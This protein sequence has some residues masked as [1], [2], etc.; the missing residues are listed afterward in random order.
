MI[1]LVRSKKPDFGFFCQIRQ[2]PAKQLAGGWKVVNEMD[3]ANVMQRE[4][5]AG[6]NALFFAAPLSRWS[7]KTQISMLA[8]S[9]GRELNL[10]MIRKVSTQAVLREIICTECHA[11]YA[12]CCDVDDEVDIID[13]DHLC[14]DV[15][16]M[17]CAPCSVR[18]QHRGAV[19]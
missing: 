5:H 12:A 8:K 11:P 15:T 6:L 9:R 16:R 3:K 10:L 2:E 4:C 19:R 17:P 14:I 18:E 1:R 7:A 13:R